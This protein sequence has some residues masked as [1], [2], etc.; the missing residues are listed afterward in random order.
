M[1]HLTDHSLWLKK[2]LEWAQNFKLQSTRRHV[3]DKILTLQLMIVISTKKRNSSIIES[4]KIYLTHNLFFLLCLKKWWR[5]FKIWSCSAFVSVFLIKKMN[6]ITSNCNGCK[7]RHSAIAVML[8]SYLTHYLFCPMPTNRRGKL[9][10][11]SW[12]AFVGMFL[13][14]N[15]LHSF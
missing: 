9:K 14:R 4:L 3:F 6:F 8:K 10:I 2:L 1:L 7:K 13:I 15:K 5:K 12:N 11:W